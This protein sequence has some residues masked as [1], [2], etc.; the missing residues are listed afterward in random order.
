MENPTV[1][2]EL[3]PRSLYAQ[4]GRAYLFAQIAGPAP[5]AFLLDE[6]HKS[7]NGRWT[8][9]EWWFG[10]LYINLSMPSARRTTNAETPTA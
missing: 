3:Q 10:R 7:N 5:I 9:R 8:E 1:F 4:L 2:I 6:R